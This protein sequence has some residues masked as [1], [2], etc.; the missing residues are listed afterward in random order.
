[1]GADLY[2]ESITNAA[3]QKYRPQWEHWIDLRNQYQAEH[4]EE[5]ATQ[6]AEKA[7]R[8]FDKMYPNEGYFRDS[9][10]SSSLLWMFKISWWKDVSK[11]MDENGYLQ[12]AQCQT[13][14]NTMAERRPFFK[15]A[16]SELKDEE[17]YNFSTQST[18]I[19]TVAEQRHYFYGKE[20]RFRNFLQRAIDM[21]EAVYCSI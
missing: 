19:E 6:A 21:N 12:P 10:N 14:L 9:Y 20:R 16:L 8:Y 1:M 7:D 5:S 15:L 2:I 3:R 18:E 13:L 17:V 11:L 4:K